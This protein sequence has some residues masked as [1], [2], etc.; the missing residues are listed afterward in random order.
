M[1]LQSIEGG[2]GRVAIDVTARGLA[3][4]R[5]VERKVLKELR[6]IEGLLV[7]LCEQGA[8]DFAQRLVDEKTRHLAATARLINPDAPEMPLELSTLYVEA[9]KKESG[10]SRIAREIQIKQMPRGKAEFAPF[11]AELDEALWQFSPYGLQPKDGLGDSWSGKPLLGG[12]ASETPS[13]SPLPFPYTGKKEAA[14]QY[15]IR[16]SEHACV[17]GFFTHLMEQRD[18]IVEKSDA[19]PLETDHPCAVLDAPPSPVQHTTIIE[20]PVSVYK[21]PVF[22]GDVM[23][24]QLAW[25]NNGPVNQTQIFEPATPAPP[26]SGPLDFTTVASWKKRDR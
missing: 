9:D 2:R 22:Y 5:L 12:G 23:D 7:E 8:A 4:P 1:K 11:T 10:A 14:E 26:A 24:S 19:Y 16:E 21:G 18:E 20:G 15:A 3:S 25:D 17:S 6:P 13:R